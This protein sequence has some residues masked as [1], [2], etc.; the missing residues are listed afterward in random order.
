MCFFHDLFLVVNLYVF[1]I[2]QHE[3]SAL[4][5]FGN[6]PFKILTIDPNSEIVK[7]LALI[8]IQIVL[9]VLVANSKLTILGQQQ[10]TALHKVIQSVLKNGPELVLLDL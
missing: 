5:R 8:H 4:K 2:T 3:K 9:I 1:I 7:V 6:C 10:L